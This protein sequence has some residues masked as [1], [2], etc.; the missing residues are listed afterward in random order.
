MQRYNNTFSYSLKSFK[1]QGSIAGIATA[2]SYVLSR[3]F[4]LLGC[5]SPGPLGYKFCC[6]L[7]CEGSQFVSLVLSSLMVA[8]LTTFA[9]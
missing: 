2:C 6:S 7:C 5:H 3:A 4:A 8:V 1:T 9:R